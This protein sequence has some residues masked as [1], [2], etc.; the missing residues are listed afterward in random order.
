M[1]RQ[2]G[3]SN[4]AWARQC[5]LVNIRI[6]EES[7]HLLQFASTTQERSSRDRQVRARQTSYGREDFGSE[8]KD[9]FRSRQILQ[10]MGAEVDELEAIGIDECSGRCRHENLPSMSRVRDAA[11]AMDVGSDIPPGRQ[12]RRSRM[13]PN[14]H[15]DWTASQRLKALDRGVE[16]LIRGWERDEEG[17]SLR[18]HLGSLMSRERRTQRFTVLGQ[19]VRVPIIAELLKEL[20]GTRDIREDEC[21]SAAWEVLTHRAVL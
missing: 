7:G 15:T 1:K 21:H 16:G 10:A 11:R 2:A 13:D 19:L 4:S 3:L 8:L 20:R 18:I 5:Q 6:K 17:I 9:P 14:P 12:Q